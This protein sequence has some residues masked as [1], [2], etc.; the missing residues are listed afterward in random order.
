MSSAT[1]FEWMLSS[2]KMTEN[3]IIATSTDSSISTDLSR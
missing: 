1:G 3:D 2:V